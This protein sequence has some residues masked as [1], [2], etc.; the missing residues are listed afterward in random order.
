MVALP[1]FLTL[2]IVKV[3]TVLVPS[4]HHRDG[5]SL[6]SVRGVL[7]CCENGINNVGIGK[8][9][10]V[11]GGRTAAH[12]DGCGGKAVG[13]GVTHLC[14]L[15]VMQ[16]RGRISACTHTMGVSSDTPGAWYLSVSFPGVRMRTVGRG[17]PQVRDEHALAFLPHL[18]RQSTNQCIP[19]SLRLCDYPGK[20]FNRYAHLWSCSGCISLF[21][22]WYHYVMIS[23]YGKQCLPLCRKSLPTAAPCPSPGTQSSA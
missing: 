16:F 11:V 10:D 12:L 4:T 9:W 14:A 18:A 8:G 19:S 17:L 1:L 13:G 3:I 7:K 22:C 15:G 5:L 21:M 20:L 23:L 6:G 2:R